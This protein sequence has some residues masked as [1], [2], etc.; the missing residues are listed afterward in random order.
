MPRA[1]AKPR[2]RADFAKQVE[3]T[4]AA[5]TDAGLTELLEGIADDP[6]AGPW[7]DWARKLT[8]GDDADVQPKPKAKPRRGK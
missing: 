7:A 6:E 8:A 3:R 2:V 1:K 4:K 5:A